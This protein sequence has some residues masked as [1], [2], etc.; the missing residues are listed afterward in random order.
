MELKTTSSNQADDPLKNHPTY[1]KMI[2]TA[3]SSLNERKGSSLKAI[4]KYME[5]T[6]DID[7]DLCM[8]YTKKAIRSEVDSGQ[9]IQ[10]TGKGLN[11]SFKIG[12]K[13]KV[14]KTRAKRVKPV[15][16]KPDKIKIIA[17]EIVETIKEKVMKSK[18]S[19]EKAPKRKSVGKMLANAKKAKLAKKM[20]KTT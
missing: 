5:S 11:G 8:R 12:K 17:K 15:A 20:K 18:T 6:Y 19:K 1:A 10:S 3:V 14:K 9:L 2:T 4:T 13:V 7:H 16:S